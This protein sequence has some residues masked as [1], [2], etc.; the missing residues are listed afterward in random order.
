VLMENYGPS[1]ARRYRIDSV[2]AASDHPGL[3]AISS[4][5]YGHTGPWS[6]YRA[7]AYNLHA[8]SG[9]QDLTRGS[10]GA[11]VHVEMAL[12]DLMTGFALATLVAAWAVGSGRAA[13]ASADIAMSELVAARLSEF[14]AAAELGLYTG[15]GAR[16]NR[17][18]PYAPN[19]V[20]ASAD[21]RGVAISVLTD[22]EWAALKAQLGN[23][24]SLDRAEWLTAAGRAADQ[25]RMDAELA[26]AVHVHAADDL[27]AKLSEAGV[28]AAIVR[29]PED[30]VAEDGLLDPVYLPQVD[31][32]LWR[33][34]RLLG[35]AW[36][37]IGRG[38]VK[39]TAP[40]PLGSARTAADSWAREL[41]DVV[42]G[43]ES[44]ANA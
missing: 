20:Y 22:A 24:V 40:P 34:R 32:P 28:L 10:A 41:A 12:A 37:F 4:S 14:V 38:P 6:H 42:Q 13:G 26:S 3:L 15:T 19:D 31:H 35:L 44:A 39:I 11:P 36:T 1:R 21:G 18:T 30:L 2:Q 16:G 33:K 29:S 43:L 8:S 5:G 9:L 7:Y 25:D 17:Q 23:T 27:E